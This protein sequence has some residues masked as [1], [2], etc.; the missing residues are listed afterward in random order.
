[1]NDYTTQPTNTRID[2]LDILGDIIDY[3]DRVLEQKEYSQYAAEKL[4]KLVSYETTDRDSG[5]FLGAFNSVFIDAIKELALGRT[6]MEFLNLAV[7]R[8]RLSLAYAFAIGNGVVTYSDSIISTDDISDRLLSIAVPRQSLPE[9]QAQK[10][11]LHRLMSVLTFLSPVFPAKAIKALL[12]GDTWDNEALIEMSVAISPAVNTAEDSMEILPNHLQVQ[13]INRGES[14]EV[15]DL[16][17]AQAIIPSSWLAPNFTETEYHV[18]LDQLVVKSGEHMACG[19]T[20]HTLS[21]MEITEGGALA[22]T[23][24][25][26]NNADS[27]VSLMVATVTR[28]RII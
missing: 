9:V 23:V 27:V 24:I 7:V 16:H 10:K 28:G 26:G 8:D 3:V 21:H 1:M 22:F 13:I 15:E 20:E 25:G 19:D 18:M 4:I 14:D 17:T 11:H 2:F 5:T 6:H 12:S